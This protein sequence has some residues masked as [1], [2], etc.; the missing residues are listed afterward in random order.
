M[1]SELQ[2]SLRGTLYNIVAIKSIER[3]SLIKEKDASCCCSM[4]CAA[5]GN[6]Q[7]EVERSLVL[8]S[9][10]IS[11]DCIGRTRHPIGAL[12]SPRLPIAFSLVGHL[13]MGGASLPPEAEYKFP[14][15]TRVLHPSIIYYVIFSLPF[16]SFVLFSYVY[17]Y[18]FFF[19]KKCV[20]SHNNQRGALLFK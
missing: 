6:S 15:L 10:F 13:G 2:S 9:F 3:K 11:F 8:F 4:V 14:L 16:F 12:H 5:S 17:I 20:Y 1:L 19:L 7:S 18:F